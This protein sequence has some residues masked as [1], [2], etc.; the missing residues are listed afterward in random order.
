MNYPPLSDAVYNDLP[1]AF[2]AM[3]DHDARQPE[4]ERITQW[5]NIKK[6][7]DKLKEWRDMKDNIRK[8]CI[9]VVKKQGGG[10]V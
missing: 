9:A 2:K 10:K 5:Y 1:E 3:I 7:M 8:G 6:R 4:Y